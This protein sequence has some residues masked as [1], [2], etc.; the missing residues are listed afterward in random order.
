MLCRM[1]NDATM[2]SRDRLDEVHVQHHVIALDD[3]TLHCVET[4][5]GPLVL[6]LHGFPE[7]WYTWRAI[8]PALARAGFRVVAP[9]LRGYNLSSKPAGVAAYSLPC[10]AND[11][12]RL[13]RAL[14]CERASVIGHD[15]GA[16]VAWATAALHPD[17]VDRLAV[18]NGPHP[19]RLLK[20]MFNPRQLLRSW[21][22][23]AIQLPRVPERLLSR[24]DFAPIRR[25]LRG[26]ARPGAF[27][28]E[29]LARYTEAF[30]QPGALTAMLNYYRAAFRPS[31]R[32][33]PLRI[34]QPTLVLWGTQDPHLGRQLARPS[35]ELVPRC[36]VEYVEQ[37]G[38]YVHHDCPELVSQTL[39]TF[40]RSEDARA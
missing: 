39:V 29:D 14:G 40:L 24:D 5:S 34:E 9:D 16:I 17:R 18:M 11:I 1:P 23:F 35:P 3:V 2:L 4:G 25:I 26:D 13:I 36:R 6:L 21:Y 19:R 22:M 27:T 12:A 38:H 20:G 8:M 31:R 33:Q 7:F 15:W 37:A 30:A 10:L 32:A 28:D